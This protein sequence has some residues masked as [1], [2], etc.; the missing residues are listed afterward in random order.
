MQCFAKHRSMIIMNN[1]IWNYHPRKEI[2]KEAAATVIGAAAFG[3]TLSQ[4][5]NPL[6]LGIAASYAG[7]RTI[8]QY[9]Y[10]HLLPERT[11]RKWLEK[12]YLEK[13]PAD[14]ELQ[15]ITDEFTQ[16][17][18]KPRH[19]AFLAKDKLVMAMLPAYLKPVKFFKSLQEKLL[20]KTRSKVAG[21]LTTTDS[22][23]ATREFLAS[24]TPRQ[25]RF[26]LAHE[27]S[28]AK[29][30]DSSSPALIFKVAK[31]HMFRALAAGVVVSAGA[32]MAGVASVPTLVVGGIS[33]LKAATILVVGSKL[34]NAAINYSGRIQER[35]ADR[36][37]MYL[38]RDPG[39]AIDWLKQAEDN[40][41]TRVPAW[42]EIYS[43]P[44]YY[45]RV[46]NIRHAWEEVAKYPPLPTARNAPAV[47]A[48][49]LT[50]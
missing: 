13:I 19:T 2:A 44:T 12:S 4:V 26:V 40:K 36:N 14:H 38:T 30:E 33:L 20:Q 16:T 25:L 10:M 17:L 22:V 50:P 11:M 41:P 18:E 47:T 5:F 43:H 46:E 49:D 34:A 27:M 21:A 9:A 39:A 1:N 31:K 3:L 7:L 29:V 45:P 8:H 48:K 6:A 42:L 24:V 28:H 15:A 23:M 35:R 37:A 32:A